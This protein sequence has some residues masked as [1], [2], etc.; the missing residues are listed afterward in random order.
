ML[1]RRGSGRSDRGV[2]SKP[3]NKLENPDFFVELVRFGELSVGPPASTMT[4]SSSRLY[5]CFLLVAERCLFRD[6]FRTLERLRS[7][8]SGLVLASLTTTASSSSSTS[9]LRLAQMSWVLKSVSRF[10]PRD[11]LVLLLLDL[12]T[13]RILAAFADISGIS[14]GGDAMP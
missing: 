14:S 7:A 2:D 12:L 6:I 3:P 10:L 8:L 1:R 13:P 9:S 5:C 4:M 11:L